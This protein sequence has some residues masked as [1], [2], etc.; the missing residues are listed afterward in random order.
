MLVGFPIVILQVIVSVGFI[1]MFVTGRY[2]EREEIE[3]I[4]QAGIEKNTI[5][6]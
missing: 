1:R 6:K 5:A 3:G 2:K 4:P